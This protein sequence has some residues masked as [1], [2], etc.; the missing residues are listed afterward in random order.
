MNLYLVRHAEALPLGQGVSRD[1][2]RPLS[3]RGEHA[4]SMVG[5]A[6]A[7]LDPAVRRIGTSPL[8]R[9]RRT[10]EIIAG[11]F[12]DA[13]QIQPWRTLEPGIDM[14]DLLEEVKQHSDGPL[15]LVAHQPDL[16]EFLSWL[17]ADAAVELA[18]PPGA[19][20]GLSLAESSGAS[21][22]RLQWVVT[23]ALLSLLNPE[24]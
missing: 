19:A 2:D 11:Q 22:A 13:P 24:W 16:S 14:E 23:P 10:A 3:T 9:A 6:L 4:A 5:R 7:K 20:A 21:G 18:F 17:V 12:A 1:A 15:I 8:L